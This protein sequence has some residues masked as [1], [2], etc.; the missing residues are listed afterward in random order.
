MESVQS[1]ISQIKRRI[2]FELYLYIVTIIMIITLY[3]SP[4]P[5]LETKNITLFLGL[6]MYDVVLL[7]FSPGAAALGLA[8]SNEVKKNDD[9]H[10]SFRPLV[11]LAL[12]LVI[13]LYFIGTIQDDISSVSRIL[14]LSILLGYQ[15]PMIWQSQEKTISK[16]V[17]KKIK[18]IK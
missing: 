2:P 4:I 7:L 12:G 18:E 10:I 15:A 17:D 1:E 11:G 9:T 8:V 3:L 16:L 5:V 13:A 6:N 14:A